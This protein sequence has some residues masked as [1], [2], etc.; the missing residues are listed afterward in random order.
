LEVL[1]TGAPAPKLFVMQSRPV[2][3]DVMWMLAEHICAAVAPFCEQPLVPE[4]LTFVESTPASSSDEGEAQAP[5]RECALTIPMVFCGELV[6]AIG[7][8]AAAEIGQEHRAVLQLVA[9][10]LA[11]SIRNAQALEAAE[12]VS[13]V[14]EL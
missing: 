1:I 13:L 12:S 3:H 6:G 11:S 8:S 4:A 9:Y 2:E 14:A 5:P 7:V 10:Q